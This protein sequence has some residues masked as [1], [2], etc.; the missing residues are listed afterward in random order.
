MA[1]FDNWEEQQGS[2]SISTDDT[3]H[4]LTLTYFALWADVYIGLP[5]IGSLYF[6][7]LH[8]YDDTKLRNISIKNRDAGA[9]ATIVLVY[10]SDQKGS[11]RYPSERVDRATVYTCSVGT[12]DKGIESHASYKMTWNHAL[13]KKNDTLIAEPSYAEQTSNTITDA[14]SKGWQWKNA[15]SDIPEGWSVAHDALYKGTEN[16]FVASPIVVR[17]SYYRPKTSADNAANNVG[18]KSTP[19]NTFGRSGGEWLVVGAEVN[20]EDGFWVVETRYQYADKWISAI[21]GS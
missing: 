7:D 16:Y 8:T 6:G 14:E 15:T 2:P 4:V 5:E 19:G 10:K 12:L 17:R 1:F 18:S 21:Y 9:R 13:I 20:Y 11:G 3:G